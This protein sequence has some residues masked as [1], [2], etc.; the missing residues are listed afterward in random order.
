LRTAVFHGPKH[1]Q[2]AE[3]DVVD[4]CPAPIRSIVNDDCDTDEAMKH[5]AE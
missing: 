5:L 4:S 2:I 1:L 3:I